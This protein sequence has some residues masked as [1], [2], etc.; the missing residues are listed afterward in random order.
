MF[1]KGSH[2]QSLQ[3]IKIVKKKTDEFKWLNVV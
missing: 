2:T 3:S 1:N